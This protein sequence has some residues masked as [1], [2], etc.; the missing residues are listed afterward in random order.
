MSLIIVSGNPLYGYQAAHS[1]SSRYRRALFVFDRRAKSGQIGGPAFG[2]RWLSF[3]A[4]EG[5]ASELA[6]ALGELS[7]K[8]APCVIIPADPAA[9]VAVNLARPRVGCAIFPI[10]DSACVLEFDDKG[11]FNSFCVKADIPMPMSLTFAHKRHMGF[12]DTTRRLGLPF[13]VKP[14]NKTGGEGYRLIGS[15]PD[16]ERLLEQEDYAY[17][18]LVAQE[19][20]DGEDIDIS[21]LAV[22]GDILNIAVQRNSGGTVTFIR[23]E[24][25]VEIAHRVAGA[26]RYSG[27]LHLDGRRDRHSGELKLIEANPRGWGSMKAATWCGLD[28]ISAGISV[29]LGY[30]PAQPRSI[31]SGSYPGFPRLLAELA[32]GC[33]RLA[34]LDHC[35]WGLIRTRLTAMSYLADRAATIL[36]RRWG[37]LRLPRI[38]AKAPP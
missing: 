13:V 32:T 3:E 23:D 8:H 7:R 4:S 1:L 37:S 12:D 16:L 20:I 9:M 29:A 22:E 17:A 10:P 25:A 11:A 31:E 24:A 6:I 34:D 38:P 30:V 19:F 26:S 15:E 36:R 5:V 2:V 14:I 35:Q 33:R 21:L 27:L 28:F 18:P